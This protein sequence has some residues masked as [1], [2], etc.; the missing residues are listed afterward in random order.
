MPVQQT[1]KNI[2]YEM[3]E[4][5]TLNEQEKLVYSFFKKCGPSTDREVSAYSNIDINIITGRRNDL[6]KKGHIYESN[7]RKCLI[8]GNT[9]IEW[10]TL[11]LIPRN[12]I[13]EKFFLTEYIEK[14][15]GGITYARMNTVKKYINQM[16]DY[17][18]K[19]LMEWLK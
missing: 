8:T 19:Q 1:S 10:S 7:K 13:V 11:S 16:N 4:N 17:Q 2:Y 3:Q 15:E 6:I 5:G 14:N 12:I 9:A 18:K